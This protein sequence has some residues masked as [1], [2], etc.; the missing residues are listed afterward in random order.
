MKRAAALA[1]AV[2]CGGAAAPSRPAPAIDA[3]V[4]R[5][6]GCAIEAPASWRKGPSLFGDLR[7]ELDVRTDGA[8]LHVWP[9][10]ATDAA[11]AE[12]EVT[13][14][15]PDSG[16]PVTRFGETVCLERRTEVVCVD[17]AHHAAA[18]MEFDDGVRDALVITARAAASATGFP[19][20]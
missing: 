5:S 10:A 13:S 4:F 20:P 18:R 11:G 2:G 7:C 16:A 14:L 9:A 15:L 17:P 12:R 3:A 1:L 19:A 8:V 6:G